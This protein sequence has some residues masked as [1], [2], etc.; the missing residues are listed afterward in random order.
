MSKMLPSNNCFDLIKRFESFR[1]TAYRPTSRD[2]WTIG[3][4]HTDNVREGDT[5]TTQQAQSY[6]AADCRCAAHYV[7]QYVTVPLTQAM[8][9][10]L[11]SFVFN[12]GGKNFEESGLLRV[13]N[14][15]QYELAAD[16][17]VRWD[18]QGGKVMEGLLRR[19]EA[20]RALFLSDG[21]AA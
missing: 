5:C 19:R 11:V 7:N 20:E 1:P 16:Q 8:F 10:A 13:L 12:V 14:D 15:K 4:G 2:V 6:L 17:L 3:Y 18:H 9:D 21:A